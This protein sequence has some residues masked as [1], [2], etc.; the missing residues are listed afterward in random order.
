V[1]CHST[2]TNTL[3]RNWLEKMRGQSEK[4]VDSEAGGEEVIFHHISFLEPFKMFQ[5]SNFDSCDEHCFF[6]YGEMLNAA[7]HLRTINQSINS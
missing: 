6:I 3:T 2:L 1:L 5:N 7:I 4:Q